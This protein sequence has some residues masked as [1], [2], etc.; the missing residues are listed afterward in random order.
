MDSDMKSLLKFGIIAAISGF[1][2]WMVLHVLG[3]IGTAATAPGRVI[4]KTLETNNIIFNYEWYFDTNAAY[5]SRVQQIAAHSKLISKSKEP[6]KALQIELAA[7]EQSCRDLVT[8][9]NANSA[10]FNRAIFKSNDLPPVLDISTC[11]GTN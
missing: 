11:E 10:K 8:K 7:M 2:L 6:D 3:V 9:Y 5:T 4:N 1:V